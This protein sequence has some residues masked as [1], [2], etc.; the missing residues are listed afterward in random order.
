MD[1]GSA[2]DERE[3]SRKEVRVNEEQA[4][5]VREIAHKRWSCGVVRSGK[6]TSDFACTPN[7]P[8]DSFWR[9]GYRYEMSIAA[10]VI[11]Q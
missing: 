6:G 8:H 2:R 5:I 11:D 10:E 3:L 7:E 9:C 1:S 4:R